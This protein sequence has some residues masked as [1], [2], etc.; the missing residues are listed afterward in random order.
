VR[1]ENSFAPEDAATS[2][3]VNPA[4]TASG[5][6]AGSPVDGTSTPVISPADADE[7]PEAAP[8][9]SSDGLA[10]GPKMGKDSCGGN[11]ASVS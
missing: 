9:D 10:P 1:E 4:S 2:A 5:G 6:N 11:K 8:N 7:D 3:V